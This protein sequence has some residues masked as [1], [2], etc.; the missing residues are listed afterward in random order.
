MTD[1]SVLQEH[2]ED[3]RLVQ[4]MIIGDGGERNI[5]RFSKIDLNYKRKVHEKS[6]QSVASIVT[7]VIKREGR[8]LSPSENRERCSIG[9]QQPA[10]DSHFNSV[11]FPYSSSGR[12]HPGRRRRE[13]IPAQVQVVKGVNA[14]RQD[15]V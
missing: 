14:G 8:S 4:M 7:L 3:P 11:L 6:V 12:V 10:T 9:I 2:H 15:I 5:V 1:D 13:R